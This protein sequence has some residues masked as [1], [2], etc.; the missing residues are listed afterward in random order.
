MTITE[1]KNMAR[2]INCFAI[3]FVLRFV[4]EFFI[5]PKLSFN[6]HSMFACTVGIVVL[7]IY[8]W[9]ENKSFE[10]IGLI[11]SRRKI[12]KGFL[13]AVLLNIIPLV[14]VYPLAYLLLKS[15]YAYVRA[16]LYFDS[17][18]HS[19][20]GGL[21][22]FLLL[23]AAALVVAVV[24]AIFYELTFRGLLM[25]LC[26]KTFDFA[27][28]NIIQASLYTLWFIISAVRVAVF[29]ENSLKSIAALFGFFLVYEFMVAIKLGLC[30][31]ASGALWICL[32]DHMAFCFIGDVLHFQASALNGRI[33]G[34]GHEYL[35]LVAYQAVSLLIAFIYFS[36][37]KKK[38]KKSRQEA[39]S[40]Q[41]SLSKS[42]PGSS[43]Q[44]A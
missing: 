10:G 25:R 37:R 31:Y 34:G 38:I 5:L 17:P 33:A 32:F 23:I 9:S 44:E 20:S 30:K 4:E 2:V 12:K 35:V 29:S 26:S 43:E 11:F 21:K 8:L 3:F 13:N 7:F 1:K 15:K 18:R 24:H 28:T 42:L 14:T 40:R 6:T 19:F 16:T 22:P 36:K 27:K 41:R 39:A